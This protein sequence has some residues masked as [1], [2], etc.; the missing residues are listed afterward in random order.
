MGTK[1]WTIKKTQYPIQIIVNEYTLQNQ[2]LQILS[3]FQLSCQFCVTHGAM[4]VCGSSRAR[5]CAK[6]SFQ[7]SHVTSNVSPNF[8]VVKQTYNQKQK[9]KIARIFLLTI[10]MTSPNILHYVDCWLID[11][12]SV[13]IICFTK[14]IQ[15]HPIWFNWIRIYCTETLCTIMYSVVQLMKRSM[16]MSFIQLIQ[17]SIC[18][19]LIIHQMYII[20]WIFYW[21]CVTKL[22]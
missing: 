5:C 16:S 12:M 4:C 19:W 15:F 21:L 6:I 2:T 18:K 17:L 9:N 22:K 7:Q 8:L 3:H 14:S 10:I 1:S 11:T 13:T 20:L